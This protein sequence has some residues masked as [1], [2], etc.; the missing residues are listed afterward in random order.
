MRTLFS[1]MKNTIFTFVILLCHCTTIAQQRNDTLLMRSDTIAA[2]K[3]LPT[4][5]KK[6]FTPAQ[7][8]IPSTMVLYGAMTTHLDAFLDLNEN[9]QDAIWNRYVHQPLTIDNYLQWVPAVAVYGLNLAGVH[10]QH[11]LLD[12]TMIYLLAQVI[13]NVT[14]SSLK[15]ITH[16]QRPNGSD[17]LSFPSG[18][19]AEAFLSAEFLRQEYKNVSVW[20]GVGGY[21]VASSV[22]FLRMYNNKHWLN[23]VIAGAGFGIISTRLAYVLYPKI[24]KIFSHTPIPNSAIMPY[25]QNKSFG[26]SLVHEF[27]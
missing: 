15:E 5:N 24:K 13:M 2:F 7:W 27:K 14:V 16:E 23:D 21:A 3:L 25:Y 19:T 26:V 18:H 17:F 11:N 12:R 10:G 8:I 4:Q 20:Y 22:A 1:L 6:Q 9:V